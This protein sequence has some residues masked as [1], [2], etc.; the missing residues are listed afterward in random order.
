MAQKNSVSTMRRIITTQDGYVFDSFIITEL[1][2]EL[3]EFDRRRE[4]E[5]ALTVALQ[6]EKITRTFYY[7]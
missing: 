7:A 1:N 4:L 5:Q 6:S 2:G 3:V